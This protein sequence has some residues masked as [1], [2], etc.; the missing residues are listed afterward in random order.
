MRTHGSRSMRLGLLLVGL[1]GMLVLGAG[2]HAATM[3]QEF[4]LITP[5]EAA[6]APAPERPGVGRVDVS[7]EPPDTGP[8]IEVLKPADGTVP[9][10]PME[11]TIRFMP[12]SA[13]VDITTL[14]ISVVK[15][16]SIDITDRVRPYVSPTG[17]Q[18]ADAKLPSGKHIVRISLADTGGG[19]SNKQITMSIP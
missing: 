4:W 16:I 10:V 3:Q 8:A 11:V 12:R 5:E 1:V 13:P 19:V 9:T 7:R 2:G 14:Q 17:I 6:M 15:F 18:I